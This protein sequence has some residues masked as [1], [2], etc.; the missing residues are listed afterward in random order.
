MRVKE[1]GEGNTKAISA[2]HRAVPAFAAGEGTVNGVGRRS[3]EETQRPWPNQP[4]LGERS[5]PLQ[6]LRCLCNISRRKIPNPHS[7]ARHGYVQVIVRSILRNLIPLCPAP[8]RLEILTH[9][10][11][12]EINKRLRRGCVN[13]D[14]A[15]DANVHRAHESLAEKVEAVGWRVFSRL[16]GVR[17]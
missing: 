16:L 5:Q 13:P 14:R 10:F 11:R 6:T 1:Q 9:V 12:I 15:K 8:N 7:V 4:I 3:S 17:R 2:I